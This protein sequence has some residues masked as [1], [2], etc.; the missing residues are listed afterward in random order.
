[1]CYDFCQIYLEDEVVIK[2]KTEPLIKELQR[3]VNQ[4]RS[5]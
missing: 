5:M 2:K 3:M 1:M 4:I